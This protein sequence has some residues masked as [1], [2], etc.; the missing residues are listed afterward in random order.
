MKNATVEDHWDWNLT[1]DGIYSSKTAYQELDRRNA[2]DCTSLAAYGIVWNKHVPLKIT[3]FSWKL[4]Q[5]R[6]PTMW[7]LLQRG[8]FNPN[9][10]T[11][12]IMCGKFDE[13][14]KHI[15][16]DCH[17]TIFVW[18][19]VISW[20]DIGKLRRAFSK[21]HLEEFVKEFQGKN[22]CVANLIWQ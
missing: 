10:S 21:E 22:K 19:K 12:C 5:D 2:E 9:F 13:D 6:V 15:F 4:I 18:K 8:A 1:K 7:N 11:K 20:F 16:F 17:F 14:T 3:S